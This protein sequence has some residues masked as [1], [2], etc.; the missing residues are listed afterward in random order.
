MADPLLVETRDHVTVFTMNRPER[1]NAY[2]NGMMGAIDAAMQAFDADPEQY[3]GILT[4]AGDDAFCSG[5]DLGTGPARGAPRRGPLEFAQMFGVGAV[6]K[7]M[8]AAVNG[9]AV[10]G[11]CE[12]ALN[13]DI[14]I[15]SDRAWFGLFE[16]KRGMV[17]GV[18]VHLLPRMVSYGDAAW[19][20]LTTERVTAEE[21]HRMGLVQRVV[22][23][24]ALLDEARTLAA[25]IAS[26]SQVAVQATKRVM[27]MHRDALLRE[28]L[29]VYEEVL[30][31]LALSPDRE[32]GIRAFVEKRPPEFRNR[33]PG[34]D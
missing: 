33:W 5:S 20:L 22:Q 25:N 8:I 7:P 18:A 1:R 16:P 31:R 24:E 6:R 9:L 28:S 12:L 30:A 11:G 19:M 4:G 10:G 21:A 27:S 14:R 3:V 29:V 34:T 23:H 13:C 17:A 32:E 26:L 15:A 2:D